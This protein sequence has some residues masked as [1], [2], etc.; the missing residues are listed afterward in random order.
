MLGEVHA[1]LRGLEPGVEA[2]QLLRRQLHELLEI[3]HHLHADVVGLVE[4]GAPVLLCLAL[5]HAE[6][7]HEPTEGL[8]A[9]VDH[10]GRHD[11][12]GDLGDLRTLLVLL[13]PLLFGLD[14]EEELHLGLADPELHSAQDIEAGVQGGNVPLVGN[15]LD[16]ALLGQ[17]RLLLGRNNCGNCDLWQDAPRVG[18]AGF[19]SVVD[20]HPCLSIAKKGAKVNIWA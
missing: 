19:R 10:L 4:E 1:A 6:L 2:L 9:G 20:S 15:A 16:G 17:G 13:D 3:H 7:R 11:D 12:R 14:R 8:E 5:A 18:T